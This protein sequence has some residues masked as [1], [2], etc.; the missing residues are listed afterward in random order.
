VRLGWYLWLP[1]KISVTVKVRKQQQQQLLVA[2]LCFFGPQPPADPIM[3]FKL[4]RS[5][6]NPLK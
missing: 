1:A 6:L 3:Q 4:L 5:F 2:L